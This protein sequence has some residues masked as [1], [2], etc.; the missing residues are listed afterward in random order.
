R[1]AAA[2]RRDSPAARFVRRR[3][4][5]APRARPGWPARISAVGN[6]SAIAPWGIPPLREGRREQFNINRQVLYTGRG[7]RA[8]SPLVTRTTGSVSGLEAL[9]VGVGRGGRNRD[10][11]VTGG[12]VA[13]VARGD[14]APQ[15]RLDRFHVAA[16]ERL[17]ELFEGRRQN[18]A[19]QPADG[20]V[21]VG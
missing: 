6:S 13:A 7:L 8:N 21:V 14:H 15:P 5:T 3:R 9:Q 17:F 4:Q 10:E 19:G 12:L 2:A 11:A 20:N 18:R 16:V 1:A